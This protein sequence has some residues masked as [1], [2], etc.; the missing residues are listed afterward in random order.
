M[1][2]WN[3]PSR[4]QK[5]VFTPDAKTGKTGSDA[6]FWPEI[7]PD[8]DGIL[9]FADQVAAWLAGDV[10]KAA[11]QPDLQA[12]A[13]IA[14]LRWATEALLT[15][16]EKR[17]DPDQPRAPQGDPHGGQWVSTVSSP[18]GSGDFTKDEATHL[19]ALMAEQGGFTYQP[20]DDTSPTDGFMLSI[21]SDR[22]H[23][24]EGKVTGSNLSGYVGRN[25]DLLAKPDHFFGAWVDEG[26]TYLDVSMRVEDAGQAKDLCCEHSQ[27]A[28]FDLA[29]METVYVTC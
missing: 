6:W 12:D 25:K 17:Y 22:E 8:G 5:L 26:K 14:A 11:I 18:S 28:Y 10:E 13:L 16:V 23:I 29:K 19:T 9:S 2:D 1:P 24:I 20:F 7:G 27:L 4:D 3:I 15:D 21:Y